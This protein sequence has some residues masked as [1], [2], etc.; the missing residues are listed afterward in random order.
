M[1]AMMTSKLKKR[2]GVFSKNKDQKLMSSVLSLKADFFHCFPISRNQI[3]ILLG[4]YFS[5]NSSEVGFAGNQSDNFGGK[6]PALQGQ[7][8]F[9]PSAPMNSSYVIEAVQNSSCITPNEN[10][11]FQ[12]KPKINEL[13]PQIGQFKDLLQCVSKFL[14]KIWNREEMDGFM[15]KVANY[16][17]ASAS[18]IFYSREFDELRVVLNT[19]T[20]IHPEIGMLFK[21]FTSG[22]I[23]RSVRNYCIKYQ[24]TIGHEENPF[25]F[26]SKDN[27]YAI[28]FFQNPTFLAVI[29]FVPG[30]TIEPSQIQSEINDFLDFRKNLRCSMIG[31]QRLVELYKMFYQDFYAEIQSKDKLKA[32]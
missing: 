6:K 8:N 12:S 10:L 9:Q 3:A 32:S 29:Y 7:S 20:T 17:S 23:E 19:H 13:K 14:N 5:V 21:D 4:R 11:I 31:K 2:V 22:A 30:Q 28:P 25:L 15:H 27:A 18:I 1:F 24:K 26:L 16:Y